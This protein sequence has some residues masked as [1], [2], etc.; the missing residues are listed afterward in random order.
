M[1]I[2]YLFECMVPRTKEHVPIGTLKLNKVFYFVFF[3]NYIHAN[4]FLQLVMC[5][6]NILRF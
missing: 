4:H 2:E 5:L 1:P 3:A 6:N